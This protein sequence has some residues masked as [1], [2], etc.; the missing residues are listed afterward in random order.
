MNTFAALLLAYPFYLAIH[1]R[2]SAY[3]A[4]AKADASSTQGN[5][6]ANATAPS[7]SSTTAAQPSDLSNVVS[8]FKNVG[9]AAALIG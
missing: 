9:E 8:I 2:L 7:S 6:T 4:L 3:V 1:G 5:P